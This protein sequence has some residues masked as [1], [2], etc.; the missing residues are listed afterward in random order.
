MVKEKKQ[1]RSFKQQSFIELILVFLVIIIVN[2][3]SSQYY[4]Q[5]DLTK[6]KRYTLSETSAQLAKRVED[7]LYFKIYLEGENLSSRFKQLR[8]AILDKLRDFRDLSGNKIDFEFVN[9]LKDKENKEKAE[10]IKELSNRGCQY[11]NDIEVEADKENR[12]L[13]LPCGEVTYGDNKEYPINFLSTEFG[14]AEE[15]A[16]NKSIEGIEYEI[17]NVIRM[18]L[19]NNPKKLAFLYGHG[20]PDALA[21]D[22]ILASLSD[23]YSIDRYLFNLSDE[24]YLKQ[25]ITYADQIKDYDSLGKTIILKSVEKLKEYDGLVIIKPTENLQKDEAYII[26]QYIMSGRKVIWMV[27]P[28]MAEHDSLRR[29]P[30]VTFPDYN[31]EHLRNLL[32]NYGVRLNPS[33]LQDLNCNNIELNDPSR[34]NRKVPFPWVYYPVFAFTNA[35]HPI[36]KNLEVVWGQY[37][38]TLKPI[39][40]PNLTITNLLLSSNKTKLQEAPAFVDLSIVNNILNKEYLKTYNQGTQ[41]AGVLLEGEF[42]SFYSRPDNSFS[43]PVIK[44]CKNNKMIVIADGDIA[45]NKVIRSSG[46]AFPLGYDVETGRQF[47]NKKFLLNCVDYLFDENGL[48]EIRTKEINMRL[49]NRADINQPKEEGIM[50]SNKQ[51]WQ[52]FNTALPVLIIILFGVLNRIY[53][54]YK[55]SR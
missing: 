43:L 6:E 2:V 40:K 10:I 37:S 24:N 26:D 9:V 31:N 25:F 38:G 3:L 53:R 45:I 18:C 28:I 41:I 32:F 19:N 47:A 7:R 12:N 46:K 4:K 34:Q 14:K 30:K 27:D 17:A 20:E 8:T 22:D 42:K 35:E 39:S 51:K 1:K 50:L 44:N 23:N 36:V 11:Y 55:Y 49:L 33:L 13:I 15:T 48:I 5:Y 16:I 29:S 52:L 21:T 54:R